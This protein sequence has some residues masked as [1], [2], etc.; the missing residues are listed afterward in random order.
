METAPETWEQMLQLNLASAFVVTRAVLPGMLARGRG[1][2]VEETRGRGVNANAVAPS[3]I[4]T[5][6]NRRNRPDADF[7]AWVQPEA[8]AGV[9]AILASEAARDLHGA[10]VPVY[11]RS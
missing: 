8:L 10:I 11:G 6:A 7:S 5:P 1:T 9:I 2:L 4:D 3:I